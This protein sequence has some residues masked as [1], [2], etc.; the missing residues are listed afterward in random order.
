M[1]FTQAIADELCERLEAGEAIKK[2]C[3]DAHM[4]DWRTL[5]RW[6]RKY[7]EFAAQYALAR[8]ASA[9]AYE[10]AALE[11]AFKA[12]DRENSAAQTLKVQTLKW[13]A[14]VRHPRVYGPRVST[15]LTGTVTLSTLVEQ[16]HRLAAPAAPTIDGDADPETGEQP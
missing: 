3:A 10:E 16:A 5:R 4:P 13:A 9:E 2:I 7:P 6:K 8:E 15:E 12:T 11:E 1:P 14:G